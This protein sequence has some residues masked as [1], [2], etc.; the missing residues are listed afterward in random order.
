[1]ALTNGNPRRIS[2]PSSECDSA[3]ASYEPP[4]AA[5][6][7]ISAAGAQRRFAAE[8]FPAAALLKSVIGLEA[9]VESALPHGCTSAVG[10]QQRRKAHAGS[11]RSP[12]SRAR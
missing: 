11:R 4:T 9:A 1:M 3:I 5:K 8:K 7:V 12:R 10:C 6:V 2:A